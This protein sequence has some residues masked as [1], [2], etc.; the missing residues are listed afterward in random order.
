[1]PAVKF[2]ATLLRFT[3]KGEKT[4][5][6]YIN[7][8]PDLIQ[9]LKKGTKTSFRVKGKLDD[10]AI[11]AVALLPMGDGDFIMPVNGTMRKA[12]KKKEGAMID[13]KL[14]ADNTELPLSS[15]LLECLADDPDAQAFFDTLTKGHQR[16][17]SN[18]IE[19]AK[20]PETKAKR[21]AMA[22]KGL[23][24]KLGYGP[25]IRH[26]KALKGS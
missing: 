16:Y 24:M 13:V 21:I 26:F 20:T 11:N 1:M 18:W 2:T 15:D 9:R 12:L 3:K 19:D 25:M 23:N 6:T 14:E 17:F 7:I 8:T 5:W 10:Y 4:G 22:L